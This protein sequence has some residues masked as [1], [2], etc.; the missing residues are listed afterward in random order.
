MCW[1]KRACSSG[2]D[3]T[4]LC[5]QENGWLHRRGGSGEWQRIDWMIATWPP[6]LKLDPSCH[7]VTN[8][9]NDLRS[10]GSPEDNCRCRSLWCC[11][12]S[13]PDHRCV[14]L[15]YIHLCLQWTQKKNCEQSTIT[16]QCMKKALEQ[17]ICLGYMGPVITDVWTVSYSQICDPWHCHNV[18]TSTSTHVCAESGRLNNA[19]FILQL[20]GSLKTQ[21]LSSYRAAFCPVCGVCLFLVGL[22]PFLVMKDFSN[23]FCKPEPL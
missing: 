6:S 10:S 14:F 18:S 9:Y 16:V 4:H 15:L 3:R 13:A 12:M 5:L 19:A 20:E 22:S 21:I 23:W 1:Y 7:R 2:S 8:L 17:P 11:S